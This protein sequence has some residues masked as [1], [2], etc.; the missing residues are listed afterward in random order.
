MVRKTSFFLAS[1]QEEGGSAMAR[2]PKVSTDFLL[3]TTN[4]RLPALILRVLCP[5]GWL[6]G[7][8]GKRIFCFYGGGL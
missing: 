1:D 6:P 2:K 5:A 4:F 7:F 3:I 8:A